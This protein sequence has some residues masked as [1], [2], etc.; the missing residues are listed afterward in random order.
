MS[1]SEQWAAIG[2]AIWE[3]IKWIISLG[4]QIEA[5][6]EH[7]LFAIFGWVATAGLIITAIKKLRDI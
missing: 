4:G 6:K 3:L 1:T 2:N 5:A 7:P